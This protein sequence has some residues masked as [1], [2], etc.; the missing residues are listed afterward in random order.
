[1]VDGKGGFLYCSDGAVE[2]GSSRQLVRTR[3]SLVSSGRVSH[4]SLTGS[5]V[6]SLIAQPVILTETL[7]KRS[8]FSKVAADPGNRDLPH[9]SGPEISIRPMQQVR[10][11]VLPKGC[12]TIADI[13]GV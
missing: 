13:P 6:S 7:I 11:A 9:Q 5:N 1:M 4:R 3:A 2:G 8:L 10:H 12:C